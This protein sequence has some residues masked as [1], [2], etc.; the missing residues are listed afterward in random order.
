MAGKTTGNLE[1]ITNAAADETNVALVTSYNANMTVLDQHVSQIEDATPAVRWVER[2]KSSSS[3]DWGSASYIAYLS[4]DGELRVRGTA[5]VTG[6]G[7]NFV[8]LPINFAEAARELGGSIS[9]NPCPCGSIVNGH[10][11]AANIYV[12]GVF[13]NSGEVGMFLSS[14]LGKG[15]N[16]RINYDITMMPEV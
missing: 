3:S 10:W 6:Q 4:S 16:M 1:L 14:Q 11:E 9:G 7:Y 8:Y 13:Y 15:V 2:G 5:V 12:T